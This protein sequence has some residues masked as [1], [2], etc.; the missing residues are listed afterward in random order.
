MKREHLLAVLVLAA[1]V[2]SVGLLWTV[3]RPFLVP[4]A[5]AAFGA[6]LFHPLERRL[7]A[8]TGR[9]GVSSLVVT[10]LLGVAALG[11]AA[12]LGV[13]LAGEAANA[14]A[15]VQAQ[16]RDGSL[17]AMVQS[18]ANGPVVAG[19]LERAGVA[20]ESLPAM[21]A[22]QFQAAAGFFL[23]RA[24]GLA[25]GLAG[26]ALD[27]AVMVLALY[28]LLKDGAQ[29]L[30][31][32]REALPVSAEHADLFTRRFQDMVRAT[33]L[34]SSV[35]AAVQGTMTAVAFAALGLPSAAFWGFVAGVLSMIPMAGAPFVWVPAA[36]ILFAQGAWIRGLVLV[37][38][39]ALVIG[40]VDNLLRP[41]VMSSR[42]RI[43]PLLLF[44]AVLGGVVAFGPV[45]VVAGPIVVTFFLTLLD[46]LGAQGQGPGGSAGADPRGVPEPMSAAGPV[47]APAAPGSAPAVAGG[48]APVPASLDPGGPA[49]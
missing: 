31:R 44:F 23:K 24:S 8:R 35:I 17:Q 15:W 9:A 14:F 1:A 11:L 18:V 33:F 29:A 21:L 40:S 6:V 22:E 49:L 34:G 2:L 41:Y 32:L 45:G 20:P 39:G 25:Q 30:A 43:H 42:T 48:A 47:P 36:V 4:L 28:Y 13:S 10:L 27:V 37:G 7:R 38:V 16:I 26:F 5:W 3:F 19:L 46:L 12:L